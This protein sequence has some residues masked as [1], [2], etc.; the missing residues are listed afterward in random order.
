MEGLNRAWVYRLGQPLILHIGANTGEVVAGQIGS[1]L[2][3]TYAVT[4]DTINTASRLQTA[5]R[6]GQILV[7]P[8]TRRLT[9]EAFAFRALQHT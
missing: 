5:A 9:H 2:G 3:G 1:E 6:P 8:S 7:S 4:G